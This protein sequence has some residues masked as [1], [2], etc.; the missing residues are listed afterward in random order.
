MP[1][2]LRVG[3]DA[4]DPDAP[5]ATVF[6][7]VAAGLAD[8]AAV[9]RAVGDACAAAGASAA[10]TEAVVLAVDEVCANV[11]QHGYGARGAAGGG[12]LVVE[13]AREPARLVVRVTDAAAHFDPAATG[14]PRLDT[15]AAERAVGGL[16]W[17]LVRR[18]VDDVG[19]EPL[20]PRGNRV[21]LARRLA[22][23]STTRG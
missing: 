6:A 21:T 18:T 17:H 20:E 8:L 7:C 19:W 12:R 4:P 11:L 9:R 13:V 22:G 23:G 3:D 14:A 5:P 2:T 1:R 15:G 16:G 10:E